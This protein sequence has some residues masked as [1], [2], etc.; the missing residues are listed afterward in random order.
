MRELSSLDATAQAELVRTGAVTPL[1]LVDAAIARIERHDPE[2]N[3]VI[4]RLFEQ[5]RETAR[6]PQTADA[7]DAPE[8]PFRGVPILVKDLL[9]TVAGAPYA[10]GLRLLKEAGYRARHDSYLV[11]RL[12]K[13]G[14]VIV[15][16]S[17]CSELGIVPTTEP[18]AWGPTRNPWNAAHSTGGSSGG[19]AAAVA[20]GLVPVA[21][22]N[23]GGGSIRVPSSMCGL[24]G[25]KPSR[26]RTVS[27]MLASSDFGDLTSDH[28]IS[29]TVRDS[30]LFLSITEA[31]DGALPPIGYVR[32]PNGKRLR[33]ATWSRTL[34]GDEPEAPVRRAY[35]EAIALMT[36]LGH[37]V[38]EVAPPT[39]DGPALRDAFFIVA[40]AAIA[41]V[42]GMLRM[43]DP[44][45]E[46]F[47]RAL[48]D[49]YRRQGP[50]A[51]DRA[52][53]ALSKA[54]RKYLT[55]LEQYDV[56]L[57]PTLA[58]P[59]WRLGHLSPIL[60]R[61]ELLHRT[62]R[63]VGYTPIHNAAG[64][65]AM[66]VP[67]HWTDDDVPIGTHFAA[68]PG[69]EGTLLGLAYELEAARPWKDRYAPYSYPRLACPRS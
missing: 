39:V 14:F 21:H 2:L 38:E 65:P 68:A 37:E 34:M 44:P 11:A 7:P 36:S 50:Q 43:P 45:F 49:E 62:A 41:G 20:A 23:D 67:L 3:A 5:A 47:T 25:F 19:S 32:E 18:I 16:K 17:N 66:S 58:T 56:V 8:A 54:A 48:I 69:G 6:A 61:V 31:T 15:G 22:A 26:G 28:C 24:F 1:E 33:V 53:T 60:G 59:P 57:T 9:A 42:E 51:L 52:R 64:C 40:G 35:E 29:R 13:A 55:T 27:A 63:S 10:G 12:R 30:A 46:P 4:V